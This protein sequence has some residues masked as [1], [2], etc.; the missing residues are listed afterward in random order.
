MCF[1]SSQIP[2]LLS[3][4]QKKHLVSNAWFGFHYWNSTLWLSHSL[5][6]APWAAQILP[7]GSQPMHH[8]C[9]GANSM[10]AVTLWEKVEGQKIFFFLFTARFSII[11]NRWWRYIMVINFLFHPC[12]FTLWGEELTQAC[13]PPW[14]YVCPIHS[15]AC[16][17]GCCS[18]QSFHTLYRG[19]WFGIISS[20]RGVKWASS[21]EAD[22]QM[23]TCN[24][25]VI[26]LSG[27]ISTR[28]SSSAK[29]YSLLL[30]PAGIIQQYTV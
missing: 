1:L 4:A 10:A 26:G 24:V 13:W 30:R 11:F 9:T 29:P 20:W 14:L 25:T 27:Y 17:P 5:H 16:A 19:S 8:H 7:G 23:L 12:S 6:Q 21:S 15:G 3:S 18:V 28:K 22:L 2:T